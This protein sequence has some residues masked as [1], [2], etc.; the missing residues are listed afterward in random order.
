MPHDIEPLILGYKKFKE[1]YANDANL[2]H[3]ISGY[4][5][6]RDEYFT[7]TNSA[8]QDLVYHGQQ[9]KIMVIAC[10]DSRVDPAIILNCRPGDLFVVRNVANL[11]PP[12]EEDSSTHH[13]T[14]AALEFAVCVLEVK[15]IIVFGHTQ[16]GGIKSMFDHTTDQKSFITKWMDLARP[17]YHE[18]CDKYD[19]LGE[20]E[21]VNVCGKYSLINS[22]QNLLTFS[23][24]EE[25]VK[26]GKM[27]IHGWYFDLET[28]TIQ[29]VNQKHSGFDELGIAK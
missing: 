19:Y 27:F 26:A 22:L 21:Q 6:F 24:V 16:C 23:W 8:F 9:P 25:K 20:A 14:S 10:S 1:Q 17:A 4:Q 5:K 18:V 3:L 2:R 12:Y 13:G 7:A 28:G 15:H 11:I 29:Q